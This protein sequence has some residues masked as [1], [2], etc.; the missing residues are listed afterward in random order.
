MNRMVSYVDYPELSSLPELVRK[1]RRLVAGTL[2]ITREEKALREQIDGLL[3]QAG[4][5]E[6]RC[7][8]A[9]GDHEAFVVFRASAADGRRYAVVNPVKES[10]TT[11]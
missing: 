7:D 10:A 6:V 3:E 5:N 8:V 4:V 2:R 11:T 9:V 1:Q